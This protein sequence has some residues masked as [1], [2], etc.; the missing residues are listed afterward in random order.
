MWTDL[1]DYQLVHTPIL[2][3]RHCKI[4]KMGFCIYVGSEVGFLAQDI[5][6]VIYVDGIAWFSLQLF[7]VTNQQKT[8]YQDMFLLLLGPSRKGGLFSFGR[9][10]SSESGSESSALLCWNSL[11]THHYWFMT[12][13][14]IASLIMT[15][16]YWFMTLL[17]SHHYTWLIITSST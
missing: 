15:H 1:L 4:A 14:G 7:M 12:Q 17:A 13:V 3:V 9:S 6:R 5:F 2:I 10:C 11:M 16:H 8:L